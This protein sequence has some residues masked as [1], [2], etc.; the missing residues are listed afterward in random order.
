MDSKQILKQLDELQNNIHQNIK[1][2]VHDQLDDL[3]KEAWDILF[4]LTKQ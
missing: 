1:G 3:L 2:E 4:Y